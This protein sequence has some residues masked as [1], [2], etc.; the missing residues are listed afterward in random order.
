MD[1]LFGGE[2]NDLLLNSEGDGF[3]V[4]DGGADTFFGS[5]GVDRMVG[6][7]GDDLAF[8]R[9]GT[10]F[11]WGGAGNDTL[12]GE[13][14]DNTLWGEAGDDI[15]VAW[16]GRDMLDGG[17][18]RD[19]LVGNE[20]DD[21][22]LGGAGDDLLE[23]R[24]GNDSYRLGFGA[25]RDVIVDW[26]GTDR[27]LF[28]QPVALADLRLQRSGDHLLVGVDRGGGPLSSVAD[29]ATLLNQLHADSNLRVERLVLGDGHQFQLDQLVAA[30]ASFG[31]SSGAEVSFARA[32]VR[33]AATPLLLAPGAP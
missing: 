16:G 19:T 21:T 27:V 12:N 11:M 18:G 4:G 8:G 31:L 26:G 28:T 10:D 22:L 17:D 6:G 24:T 7:D 13:A 33:A 1:T 9:G 14:G 2:G 20:G 29:V 3:A 15:L 30:M 25:G 23:G 5:E 32:D